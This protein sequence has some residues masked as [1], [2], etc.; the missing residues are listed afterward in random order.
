MINEILYICIAWGYIPSNVFREIP[1]GV[2]LSASLAEITGCRRGTTL[3]RDLQSDVRLGETIQG[4]STTFGIPVVR[5]T[6]QDEFHFSRPSQEVAASLR[7]AFGYNVTADMYPTSR[8]YTIR[9]LGLATHEAV[10]TFFLELAGMTELVGR[11]K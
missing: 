2:A 11:R 7:I 8:A 3:L 1:N 9:D 10:D 5:V 4:Q 6:E